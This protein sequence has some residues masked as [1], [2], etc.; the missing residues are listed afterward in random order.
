[1]YHKLEL[2]SSIAVPL[3]TSRR[4]NEN[5]QNTRNAV[6]ISRL[7]EE[8]SI[9]LNNDKKNF[10]EKSKVWSTND[11]YKL[12]RQVIKEPALSEK[13]E[14]M[15]KEVLGYK[16]ISECFN[17]YFAS[18]FVQDDSEV[19]VSFNQSPQTFLYDIPFSKAALN[20]EIKHMRSGANSFDCIRPKFLKSALPYILNQLLFIFGCCVSKCKFTSLWKKAQE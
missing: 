11:A 6:K 9:S 1:M 2:A 4:T 17:N 19:V 14:Y 18:V 15:E 16:I 20:E 5:F 12:I 7:G 10:A 8:L 13:M 3:K